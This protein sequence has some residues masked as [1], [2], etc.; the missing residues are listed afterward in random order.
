MAFYTF[1]TSTIISR[2]LSNFP[3]NFL[4][5]SV[6]FLELS[7]NANDASQR[8]ALEQERAKYERDDSL[9]TPDAADWLLASQILY[10]LTQERRKKAGGKAPKLKPGDTQR[11]AL[12]TLIAVSARRWQAA[13]VTENWGDFKAIQRHCRSVKIVKA[14]E[15]FG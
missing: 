5:S 12:D 8:K 11:M 2:K 13:V 10:R 7:A 6:V 15:F 3:D 9:I 4:L 14:D 1:D